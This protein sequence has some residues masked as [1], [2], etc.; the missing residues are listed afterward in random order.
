MTLVTLRGVE[1]AIIDLDTTPDDWRSSWIGAGV[2]SDMPED[3]ALVVTR[4]PFETDEPVLRAAWPDTYWLSG[5]TGEDPWVLWA[6]ACGDEPLFEIGLRELPVAWT[7]EGSN[8]PRDTAIVLLRAFWFE[9]RRAAEARFEDEC[10][11]DG[12][13]DPDVGSDATA[14]PRIGLL[15]AD[16]ARSIADAV[17]S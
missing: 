9:C 8:D 16:D 14:F 17:W 13:V 11:G 3:V 12:E 10:C 2:A 4:P 15:S 5:G 6:Q 1:I 7:R